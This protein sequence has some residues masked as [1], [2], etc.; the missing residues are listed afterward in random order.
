MSFS[1]SSAF[2]E[3]DNPHLPEGM[4]KDT[5]QGTEEGYHVY[6]ESG[7]CFPEQNIGTS[8][9]RWNKPPMGY[10]AIEECFF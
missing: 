5:D 1:L 9:V 4:E 3:K 8:K 10:P 2:S 6:S 7:V